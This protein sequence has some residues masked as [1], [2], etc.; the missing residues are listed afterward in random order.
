MWTYVDC[1]AAICGSPIW[2]AAEK[3]KFSVSC[4]VSRV[5]GDS[6]YIKVGFTDQLTCQTSHNNVKESCVYLTWSHHV[7]C[8]WFCASAVPGQHNDY[9]ASWCSTA[10]KYFHLK[11]VHIPGEI[12][13]C[14]YTPTWLSRSYKL[15]Y[16]LSR[17]NNTTVRPASMHILIWLMLRHTWRIKQHLHMYLYIINNTNIIY[18]LLYIFF[19]LFIIYI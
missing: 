12:I 14:S 8:I 13:I 4:T 2:Y 18:I 10:V 1:C 19:N 17:F 16:R 5:S 15:S 3:R 7:L 6:E 9:E 11:L